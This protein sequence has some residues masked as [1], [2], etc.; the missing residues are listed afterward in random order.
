VPAEKIDPAAARAELE[1]ISGTRATGDEA[2]DAKLKAE[3][4]ARAL[5]RAA[6]R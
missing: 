1:T 2:I 5:V 4:A 3:E 6:A